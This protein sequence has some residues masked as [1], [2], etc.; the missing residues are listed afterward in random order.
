[1]HVLGDTFP[2]LLQV[3]PHR[4]DAAEVASMAEQFEPYFARGQRYASL[5]VQ[6]PDAVNPGAHERKM[7]TEWSDSPRVREFTRTLC[8][9]TAVVLPNAIFRGALTAMMWVW[10]PVVR[11]EPVE[12]IVAGIDYCLECLEKA[13]IPLPRA[14]GA[15]RLEAAELLKPLLVP[16]KSEKR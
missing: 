16:G 8:V 4:Y 6:P 15:L 11:I 12:S 2:L 5:Y 14:A 1:M 3:G 10:K 13:A 7:I 9:G